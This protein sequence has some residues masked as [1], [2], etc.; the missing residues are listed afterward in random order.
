MCRRVLPLYIIMV[1]IVFG[2]VFAQEK[3]GL[4]TINYERVKGEIY[5]P[6]IPIKEAQNL[7][8][9][10][11]QEPGTAFYLEMGG[12]LLSSLNVDFRINKANRYGIGI[13]PISGDLVLSLM[14]YHL[15]GKNYRFEIG[16]G[17]GYIVILDKSIDREKFKGVI[18]FGVIGYRY[19]KK[20]GLLFRAGFTPLIFSDV[21]LPLVGV[22]FGYSL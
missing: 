5:Q 1:S 6:E 15:G 18:A 11:H 17:L 9:A 8:N 22:S 7:K 13:I 12:K 20:N 10:G 14:Y 3:D 2:P 4:K 21:F 16:G 19:Q